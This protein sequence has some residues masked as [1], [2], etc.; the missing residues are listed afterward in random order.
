MVGTQEY[1][2]MLIKKC[3]HRAETL[4]SGADIYYIV[5]NN[6]VFNIY[7]HFLESASKNYKF[8]IFLI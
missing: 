4:Q 7:I 5:F 8:Y 2:L 6:N 1:L 3:Y